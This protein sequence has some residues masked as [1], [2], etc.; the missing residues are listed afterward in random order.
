MPRSYG[1]RRPADLPDG[2][3]VDAVRVDPSA[4][5][6]DGPDGTVVVDGALL[7]APDGAAP[8]P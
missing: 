3:D 4:E 8:W 2:R 7:A 5:P 1:C 6:Q